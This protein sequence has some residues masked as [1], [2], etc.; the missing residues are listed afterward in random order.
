MGLYRKNFV[1]IQFL[2][3]YRFL[4]KEETKFAFALFLRGLQ[5]YNNLRML[6]GLKH[7]K[8]NIQRSGIIGF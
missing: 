8:L 4:I 6:H 2:T 1:L 5:I 3:D 7:L